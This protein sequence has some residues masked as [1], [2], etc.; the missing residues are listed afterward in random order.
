MALK[1]LMLK[2][3]IDQRSKALDALIAKDEEFV[4]RESELTKAI[5]E[6][7]ADEEFNAV[8]EEIEKLNSEKDQHEADKK[9]IEDEINGLKEELKKEEEAQET[10][11]T[12]AP[13]P[14]E[15]PKERKVEIVMNK[16]NVFADMDVQT[17]TAVFA[18]DD[19]KKFMEETRSAI[20]EKRAIQN[21]GLTI[22]E[23]FLGYIRELVP[24]YSKLIGKV[25][26]RRVNGTG[27]MVIMGGVHEAIWTECCA[28]LNEMDMDFSDTSVDCF[29]I[30]G[31]YAI[32]NSNLE[33]SDVN[34]A[35]EILDA[36]ARGI[37]YA[38]DKAILY[39]K[40]TS[41]NNKMPLGIVSRLAQTAEPTDYSA[42]E[43]AWADLHTSNIITLTAA[44]SK[45]VALFQN[46][47]LNSAVMDNDFS[48]ENVTWVMNRKTRTK[49]VAES[50]AKNASGA[51]VSALNNTMPVIGGDIVELNFIPDNV[52][53]AGYFDQYLLAERAGAKFAES[54]H[55]R[56]LEDQTVF[57]GTARYD[58]KPLI[59][60]A[61][62]AIGLDGTTPDATM[63]F[64]AD[65][66]NA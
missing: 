45:D 42:T 57:K 16:R 20:M 11:P 51:V 36:I 52:I 49:I 12:D 60:E 37:G 2:K 10:E 3:K 65:T 27:R 35:S 40:N 33:D 17:R 25:T 22:P 28:K 31:Y 46:L 29:K 56:F 54:Q 24:H 30:G 55:V 61:F 43:R 62:M 53:I 63:T 34:L 13:A 38:L 23:V 18:Q 58:G 14:A 59:A 9:A 48:M 1:A 7:E 50:M 26:V 4:T 6:A 47:V 39:G 19:V 8:N 41:S 21:V 32:C 44:Q 15:E 64:A 5:D 66:A